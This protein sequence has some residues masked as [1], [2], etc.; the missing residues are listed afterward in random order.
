MGMF[1]DWDEYEVGMCVFLVVDQ[2]I[3]FWFWIWKLIRNSIQIFFISVAVN[4][5]F[6]SNLESTLK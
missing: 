4:N 3:K 6:V 1:K 2:M 5:D